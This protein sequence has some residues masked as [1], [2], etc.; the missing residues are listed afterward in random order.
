MY[1]SATVF[2]LFEPITAK[3]RLFKGGTPLRRPRSR[4]TP[5]PSG[6][7]FCHDKLE[8]LGQLQC[9][10][11][12]PSLHRF[13]TAH[14]CDRRTAKRPD[15]GKDARSILLSRVIISTLI[16]PTNFRW[17][18]R[19]TANLWN[20]TTDIHKSFILVA[21]V[22]TRGGSCPTLP[23]CAL[24]PLQ[25]PPGE[26]LTMIKCPIVTIHMPRRD[27]LNVIF[28][29]QRR[30]LG[31]FLHFEILKKTGKFGISTKRLKAMCFSFKG[32]HTVTEWSRHLAC[33]KNYCNLCPHLTHNLQIPSAAHVSSVNR[34]T[35]KCQN[36]LNPNLSF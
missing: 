4:G 29:R 5:T 16:Y 33:T 30:Y 18:I 21:M 7:K 34:S 6:T 22:G 20:G 35:E 15:D 26:M 9:R 17:P 32:L 13:D 1:L 24:A 28:A 12:D 10:F 23:S 14:E 8:T 27:I 11:R 2:T 3:W 31:L 36:A 19:P 25:L